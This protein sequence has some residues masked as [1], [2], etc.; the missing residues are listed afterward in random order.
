MRVFAVSSVI[1]TQFSHRAMQH[2]TIQRYR[3]VLA[4]DIEVPQNAPQPVFST[5]K[6]IHD[7]Q[8]SPLVA[9]HISNIDDALQEERRIHEAQ[10]EVLLRDQNM[11]SSELKDE[12]TAY[13]SCIIAFYQNNPHDGFERSRIY[14][15]HSQIASGICLAKRKNELLA[16]LEH[17]YRFHFHAF[18]LLCDNFGHTTNQDIMCELRIHIN[19]IQEIITE[20]FE[21]L[22]YEEEN[23]HYRILEI[24][25][26]R[27]NNLRGP[28]S[29]AGTSGIE[30]KRYHDLVVTLG[31]LRK[32]PETGNF[33]RYFQHSG[34][35]SEPQLSGQLL[36]AQPFERE[37]VLS[38]SSVSQGEPTNRLVV[39]GNKRFFSKK[40]KSVSSIASK[41]YVVPV[42]STGK[43]PM[44]VSESNKFALS[45][46]YS[47]PK[48]VYLSQSG[49][50]GIKQTLEKTFKANYGPR[51]DVQ[52]SLR[53]TGHSILL[54]NK[55]ND[56]RIKM[57]R[58][59]VTL[60][61]K[62]LVSLHTTICNNIATMFSEDSSYLSTHSSKDKHYPWASHFAGYLCFDLPDTLALENG[63]RRNWLYS[64]IRGNINISEMHESD[65]L[66]D[67]DSLKKTWYFRMYGPSE[68]GQ[69]IDGQTDSRFTPVK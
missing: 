42:I 50:D 61:N 47:E 12:G 7:P 33:H 46:L 13:T 14:G 23:L 51:Q 38:Q 31:E 60:Y 34:V 69:D 54:P 56:R 26:S 57:D 10:M 36:G 27:Y 18:D 37:P 63:A 21:S 40:I 32:N 66:N 5:H 15:I 64:Q 58:C 49:F 2:D 24:T 48:E 28:T 11:I 43:H 3:V 29:D 6:V 67:Q 4:E 59:V 22:R 9:H 68:L 53:K 8:N 39:H 20:Y 30:P 25:C 65:D 16:K 62:E 35:I 17:E 55:T 52:F 45:A 41:F 19:R 1:P 44:L